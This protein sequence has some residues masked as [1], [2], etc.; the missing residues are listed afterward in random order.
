MK[1]TAS[2][3]WQLGLRMLKSLCDWSCSW[4]LPVR[5]EIETSWYSPKDHTW[6]AANILINAEGKPTETFGPLSR[7][8]NGMKGGWNPGAG[9]LMLQRGWALKKTF[10]KNPQCR[11]QWTADSLL[12]RQ[13]VLSGGYWSFPWPSFSAQPTQEKRLSFRPVTK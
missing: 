10:L 7:H 3:S 2:V 11:T 5:W 12:A 13:S 9:N 4:V 8:S 6:P 1:K